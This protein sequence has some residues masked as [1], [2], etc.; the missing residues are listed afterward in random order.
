MVVAALFR[1]DVRGCG[2]RMDFAEEVGIEV[3]G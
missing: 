3:T 2:G 1:R